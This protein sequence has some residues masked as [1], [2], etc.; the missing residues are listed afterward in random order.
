VSGGYFK[1]IYIY[2]NEKHL[3]KR[4]IEEKKRKDLFEAN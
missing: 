3:G 4:T 2:I 1:Y